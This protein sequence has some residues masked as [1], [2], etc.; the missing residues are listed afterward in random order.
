[1]S[2]KYTY[3][4]FLPDSISNLIYSRYR[5]SN[6]TPSDSHLPKWEPSQKYPVSYALIG[7]MNEDEGELLKFENNLYQE[8]V[9]FWNVLNPHVP[10]KDFHLKDEL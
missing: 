5:C 4:I 7:S 9:D 3:T 6:P 1:M 10:A 2:F 8:R